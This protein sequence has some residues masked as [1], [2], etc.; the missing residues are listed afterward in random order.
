MYLSIANTFMHGGA[1][2]NGEVSERWPLAP[3]NDSERY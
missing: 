3:V 2:V 1:T